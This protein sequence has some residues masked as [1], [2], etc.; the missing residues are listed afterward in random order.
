MAVKDLSCPPGVRLFRCLR[1]TITTIE[2]EGEVG[3]AGFLENRRERKHAKRQEREAREQKQREQNEAQERA[4]QEVFAYA[5]EVLADDLITDE[6][7]DRLADLLERATGVSVIP[8]GSKFHEIGRRV[9]IASANAGRLPEVTPEH[10]ISKKGEIVHIELIAELQKEVTLSHREFAA[11]GA[12]VSVR[13][14]KGVRV[15]TGGVRGQG[16]T[17]YDGT[18]LQTED[19]GILAVTSQRLVFLGQ[20]K[21][22]EIPYA[23]LAGLNVYSDGFVVSATNRQRTL[24][25]VGFDGPV[26]AAYANAAASSLE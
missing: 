23:K 26:A 21:T 12:G 9:A 13:I 10:L 24:M 1:G 4:E 3:V 2:V 22:L 20:R 14:A 16:Y 7:E 18:E 5:E 19:T 17:V 11:G 6:E 15:H 25:F 8:L